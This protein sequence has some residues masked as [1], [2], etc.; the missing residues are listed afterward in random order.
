M[1]ALYASIVKNLRGVALFDLNE[2]GVWDSITWLKK[3]FRY[4][5]LGVTPV[6]ADRFRDRI[7][8]YLNGNPFREL[9]LPIRELGELVGKLAEAGGI[10]LEV[11]ELLIFSSTYISPSLLIGETFSNTITSLAVSTVR[12]CRE[13][14]LKSWK[15]HL[16]IADYSILDSY[17]E[18][19]SSSLRALEKRDER[20]IREILES[21]KNAIEK[22]KKR[23]WRISCDSG[24]VFISYVDLLEIAFRKGILET[25]IQPLEIAAGLAVVPVVHIPAGLK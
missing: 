21:R 25:L 19:V 5:N 7:K 11:S 15:L 22:D 13:L 6:I 20:L 14:D 18:N 12:T 8:D 3:R 23:Y 16:R 1:F 17:E 24:R 9:V 4:R 2:E 10:P